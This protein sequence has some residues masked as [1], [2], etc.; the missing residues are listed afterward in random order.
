MQRNKVFSVTTIAAVARQL[1][2]DEGLLHEISIAMA[3]EDGV[4]WV[5]DLGADYIMAFTDE[6]VGELKILLEIH[7]RVHAHAASR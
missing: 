4:I 7:N 1:G 6:G 3:P 2:V 5:R